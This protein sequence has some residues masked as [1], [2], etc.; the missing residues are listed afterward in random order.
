MINK[1]TSGISISVESEYLGE[2]LVDELLKQVFAYHIT[3]SND[4][5]ETVQLMS[6]HWHIY[7]SDGSHTEVKGDGV[8]GMQPVIDPGHSHQYS[9]G[10]HLNGHFGKMAGT[11]LMR[12]L[13]DGFHF[14]ADIPEFKLNVPFRLN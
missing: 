3:I 9:S 5:E 2:G 8:I 14:D 6:R 10:C 11:Y 7:D 12:R 1:V 13:S 4:S